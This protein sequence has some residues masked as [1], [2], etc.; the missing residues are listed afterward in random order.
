MYMP[1]INKRY[2]RVFA[3]LKTGATRQLG[4][5]WAFNSQDA[6]TIAMDQNKVYLDKLFD[7]KI[8]YHVYAEHDTTM[9]IYK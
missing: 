1:Y 8:T 7:E 9:P 4:G 6:I 3:S 5:V 2:F